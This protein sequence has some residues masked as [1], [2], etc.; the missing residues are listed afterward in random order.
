MTDVPVLVLGA[1]SFAPEVAD[2]VG[3]MRGFRVAGFVENLDRAR[4]KRT[5]DGHPVLWI[6]DIEPFA[7]SHRAVCGL[8]TTHRRALVERA[9]ALGFDFVTIVHPSARVSRSASLGEGSVVSAGVVVASHVSIGRQVLLNRGVLLGHDTTVGGYVSVMPGANI[10]SAC[11][12]GEGSYVGMGSVVLDHTVVGAG[13]VVGAGAVVTR[14]VPPNVQ[15]VGV[16]ARVVR[17]GV[18]GL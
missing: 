1:R 4:C 8:G 13:S 11:T 14:D 17:E 15:V 7:A 2:L 10:A 9:R 5:V 18:D 16:P 3:D 6:D 12:I